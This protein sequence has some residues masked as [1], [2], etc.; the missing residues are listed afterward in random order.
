MNRST[1]FAV[2]ILSALVG[3]V[4]AVSQDEVDKVDQ[5]VSQLEGE[6]ASYKDS[7]VEA[8]ERMVK[9]VDLY[10]EHARVL[11]VA[12]TAKKFVVAHPADPRH[13]AIMLKMIDALEI[14]SRDGELEAACRQFIQKYP[15]DSANSDVGRRL[16]KSLFRANRVHDGA[17]VLASLWYR[18]AN[19]AGYREGAD[20]LA[21]FWRVNN[22][23]SWRA[24]GAVGQ[25]MFE[26]LGDAKRKQW[27][28]W[29]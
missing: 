4:P 17:E 24:A 20:A 6:L 9:L 7:S 22:G 28:G 15:K 21:A 10:Y 29:A 18:R 13:R 2:A 5:Q 19:D 11:G 23:E 25:D 3:S 14:L 8:A 12:R 27:V 16:A 26:K 1:I